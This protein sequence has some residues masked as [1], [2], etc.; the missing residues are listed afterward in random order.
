MTNKTVDVVIKGQDLLSLHR[1]AAGYYN[2]MKRDGH[3][4]DVKSWNSEQVTFM[5]GL[6][7]D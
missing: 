3:S 1:E 5:V 6:N 7:N 4:I 2:A